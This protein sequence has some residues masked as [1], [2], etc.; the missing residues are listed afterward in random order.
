MAK[1]ENTGSKIAVLLANID[2]D[3]LTELQRKLRLLKAVQKEMGEETRLQL[4]IIEEFRKVQYGLQALSLKPVQYDGGKAK[5]LATLER[6]DTIVSAAAKR[7]EDSLRA[8]AGLSAFRAALTAFHAD[9]NG[10]FPENPATELPGKYLQSVPGIRLPGHGAPTNSIDVVS[11]VRNSEELFQRVNDSGNWLYVGDKT[12]P[13]QGT[14]IFNCNHKDYD[15]TA[16]YR[17]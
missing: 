5:K 9:N 16:M 3:G 17:Y 6:I 11:G 14:L 12:S 13:I 15:G 8:K 7:T 4:E 1:A 2:T 10:L